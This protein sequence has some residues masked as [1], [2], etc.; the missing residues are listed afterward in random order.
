VRVLR[1]GQKR[2]EHLGNLGAEGFDIA[3]DVSLRQ[4]NFVELLAW[5]GGVFRHGVE[6][7]S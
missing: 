6:W 7:F 2:G 5:V 1:A 3:E 4:R